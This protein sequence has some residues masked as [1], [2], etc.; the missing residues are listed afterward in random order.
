MEQLLSSQSYAALFLVSF[1]AATVVPLGSEWL[2]AAMVVSGSNLPLAVAVASMGNYLGGVT[3]YLIGIFGGVFLIRRVLKVSEER[4]MKA[5]GW[6][7]KYGAWTLLLSWLPIVGDPICLAGG[8]MKTGFFRFS[9]LVF[10]GKL[11]R[12]SVVAWIAKEG[13]GLVR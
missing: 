9:L 13:A 1:L 3:T 7:G 10:T 5:R 4:E 2:L 8:L 11:A 12:Y 6:Y